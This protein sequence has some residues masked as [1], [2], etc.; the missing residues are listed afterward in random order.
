VSR[1]GCLVLRVR[2][3]MGMGRV[4]GTEV[5]VARTALARRLVVVRVAE[6]GGRQGR[7]QPGGEA[8][9]IVR[10]RRIH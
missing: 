9:G 10:R 2:M 7:G 1:V 6:G 8:V 4:G 5:V 3:G